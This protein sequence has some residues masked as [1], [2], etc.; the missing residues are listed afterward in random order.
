MG[1]GKSHTGHRLAALLNVPFVDLDERLETAAGKTISRIFAEDG[2]TA[3]R[4]LERDLL[5]ATA[6]ETA[7]IATGGGA[8]CFHEGMAWMNDNG[9]TV[10][11]DPP[12]P[13]LLAR[14]SAG[15]DHR[16]LLQELA[17]FEADIA[18]R[19]AAR[20]PIYEKAHIHLRPTDP[21]ADVARLLSILLAPQE[22]II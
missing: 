13:V 11:L 20:R 19:L 15:R 8:P 18:A 22:P 21:N 4:E 3:F 10:F 5:R 7:V 1:S 17:D 2:E 16:P 12:L 14:L 6:D 9:T